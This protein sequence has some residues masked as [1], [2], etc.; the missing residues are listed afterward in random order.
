[1]AFRIKAGGERSTMSSWFMIH[2]DPIKDMARKE[3]EN[4]SE[5][6]GKRWL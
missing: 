5:T 1:M 3:K 6:A 4:V 2:F